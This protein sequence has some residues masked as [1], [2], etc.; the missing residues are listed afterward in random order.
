MC[1]QGVLLASHRFRPAYYILQVALIP[2][3]GMVQ[4][5]TCFRA[6]FHHY[7]DCIGAF[8]FVAI[9]DPMKNTFTEVYA[10]TCSSPLACLGFEPRLQV[11][12][13]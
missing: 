6:G 8:V 7:I 1:E 11:M 4:M 2:N 9:G 3:S 10:F 13:L 5:T 12:R